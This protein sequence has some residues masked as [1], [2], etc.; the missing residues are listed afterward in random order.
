MWYKNK[1]LQ[2]IMLFTKTETWSVLRHESFF[3]HFPNC[4][5][6]DRNTLNANEIK[7]SAPYL[8]TASY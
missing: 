3:G 5:K 1:F 8:T 7:V 6:G 2:N 4:K